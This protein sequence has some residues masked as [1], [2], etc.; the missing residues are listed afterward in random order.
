MATTSRPFVRSATAADAHVIAG[1]LDQLGYPGNTADEV[2]ERLA[3]HRES[4]GAVL[5]AVVDDRVIG[6]VSVHSI[7]YFEKPGRLARVTSLVVDATVRRSGA[8]RAL[9]AAAEELAAAWACTAVDISSS[10]SRQDAHAFYRSLGYT[11][12]C[13]SSARFTKE[14]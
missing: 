2:V 10:R 3:L 4:G 6:S 13:S 7:P 1:L 14:F 5:V 12:K 8:G 11:D 9:I